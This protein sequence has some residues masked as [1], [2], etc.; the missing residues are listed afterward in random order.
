M[1]PRRGREHARRRAL[2]VSLTPQR[3]HILLPMLCHEREEVRNLMLQDLLLLTQLA[4]FTHAKRDLVRERFLE[5]V[6]V[7]WPL[8]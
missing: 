4:Q 6:N 5:L 2:T 8:A 1:Q 7:Y 3:T